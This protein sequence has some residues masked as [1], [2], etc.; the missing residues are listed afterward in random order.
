VRPAGRLLQA[1]EVDRDTAREAAEQELRRREYVEAQPS[2]VVRVVGRVLRELGELLDGAAALAP[3]GLLGLLALL[4]VVL[5]LVGVVLTRIGPL[6]R[7]SAAP[8]LFSGAG[9]QTAAE[10]RA[11]AEQAAA[12]GQWAQAVRERLRAVV[13]ELEARGALDPRP[14][15]TAGEVARDGGAALPHVAD[16]LARAARLFDEVWYGGRPADAA[17]YASLVAVDARV[18]DTAPVAR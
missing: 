2:L 18:S 15:R 14:G 9:A 8:S 16:D 3:G 7:A 6:A 12:Q 11:Q 17:S 5:L 10:H 13:R 4:V 1:L